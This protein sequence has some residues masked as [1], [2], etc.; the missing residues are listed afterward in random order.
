MAKIFLDTNTC[1]D[2]IES[3][4]KL[5][6][7]HLQD[8]EVVISPLSIHILIYVTR[9][10]IP[11]PTLSRLIKLFS[12]TIF[13]QSICDRSLIGPTKDFKDNAQ[14]HSASDAGCDLFL[15]RDKRLLSLQFF[16]AMKM[17]KELN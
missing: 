8:H 3:R 10:K 5:Q 11:Y 15:T 1:I 16:G 14:L 7:I 2:L 9:K 17:V 6:G 4:G 13:D 12:V